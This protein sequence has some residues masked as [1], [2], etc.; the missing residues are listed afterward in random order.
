M[1]HT[2]FPRYISPG[3]LDEHRFTFHHLAEKAESIKMISLLL[4]QGCYNVS[5]LDSKDCTPLHYAA[6]RGHPKVVKF[7]ATRPN[8]DAD[9]GD[10]AGRT[11]LHYAVQTMNAATARVLISEINVNVGAQDMDGR[12]ALH[13]AVMR[14]SRQVFELLVSRS[15]V[16]T[17]ARDKEGHTPLFYATTKVYASYVQTLLQLGVERDTQALEAAR[18]IIV[19]QLG[20]Q[21][22]Q[23]E[24]KVRRLMLDPGST[25]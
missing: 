10:K 17:G 16:D 6:G 8:A 12:T 18:D 9:A 14:S 7:L 20:E 3:L 23:I 5:P 21:D 24:I 2:W 15:G 19:G 22:E 25:I 1:S 11:P 13:H 4:S